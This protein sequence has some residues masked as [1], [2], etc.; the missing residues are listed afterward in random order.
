MSKDTAFELTY[1]RDL[2]DRLLADPNNEA[3]HSAISALWWG[4]VGSTVVLVAFFV[5]ILVLSVAISNDK[6]K[7]NQE[8][9]VVAVIVDVILCIIA[10]LYAIVWFNVFVARLVDP[11]GA[12]ILGVMS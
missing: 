9:E 7:K 12:F 6:F 8:L 4:A 3:F 11:M 5:V 2:L 10:T 1:K